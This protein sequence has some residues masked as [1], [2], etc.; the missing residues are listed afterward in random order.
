[1]DLATYARSHGYVQSF[2]PHQEVEWAYDESLESESKLE[3]YNRFLSR[4]KEILKV[5]KLEFYN[6]SMLT[7]KKTSKAARERFWWFCSGLSYS[8]YFTE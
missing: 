6:G 4:A 5:G 8:E 2:K 7:D 3:R 1:M